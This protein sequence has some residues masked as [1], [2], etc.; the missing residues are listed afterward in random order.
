MLI[1][2]VCISLKTLPA[3]KG[4][5]RIIYVYVRV[6]SNQ[7]Y[8]PRQINTELEVPLVMASSG[9][10]SICRIAGSARQEKHGT[11][12]LAPVHH[13][14]LVQSPG[15]FSSTGLVARLGCCSTHQFP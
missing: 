11:C 14:G 3:Q 5:E 6:P 12:A 4:K 15:S 10:T 13:A 1:S 7:I 9:S 8:S 2:T